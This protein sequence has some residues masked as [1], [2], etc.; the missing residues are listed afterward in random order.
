MTAHSNSAP[1]LL[2]SYTVVQNVLRSII[3][4][5]DCTSR[6]ASEV[7]FFITFCYLQ[8]RVDPVRKVWH[9]YKLSFATINVKFMSA[10]INEI[11]FLFILAKSELIFVLVNLKCLTKVENSD[12]EFPSKKKN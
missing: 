4:E 12:L 3:N 11:K 6:L 9:G 7:F 8:I 10:T 1:K 2:I 5:A